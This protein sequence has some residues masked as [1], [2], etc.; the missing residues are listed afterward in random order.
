MLGCQ[1]GSYGARGPVIGG[2]QYDNQLNQLALE[3]VPLPSRFFGEPIVRN[4]EPPLFR[5]RETRQRQSRHFAET[6][7][8]GGF[9]ATVTERNRTCFVDR[10]RACP[11]EYG[12]PTTIYNR[13]NR[14]SSRG[15]WRKMFEKIAASVPVPD[16]LLEITS[17]SLQAS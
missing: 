11:Q 15:I 3:N 12:P 9:D 1:S 6:K 8:F 2:V 10:D 14:W 13:C 7:L 16:E 4:D 5:Q 17:A